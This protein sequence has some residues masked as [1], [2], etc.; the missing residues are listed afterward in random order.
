MMGESRDILLIGKHN[1]IAVDSG[2][3]VGRPALS[4]SGAASGNVN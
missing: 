4:H 1:V 3:G 2:L